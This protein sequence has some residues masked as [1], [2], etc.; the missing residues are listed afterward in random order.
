[1]LAAWREVDVACSWALV[2]GGQQDSAL[3]HELL[4]NRDL[5]DRERNASVRLATR[6]QAEL[7]R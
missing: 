3:Q 6:L 7:R 5:A 4:R 1:M 2:E